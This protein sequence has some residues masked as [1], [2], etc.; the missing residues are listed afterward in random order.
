MKEGICRNSNAVRLNYLS[1]LDFPTEIQENI[2]KA[3]LLMAIETE[4][5]LLPKALARIAI[6]FVRVFPSFSIL[7]CTYLVNLP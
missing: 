7:R 3:L 4:L 5:R 1:T 6:I 2:S